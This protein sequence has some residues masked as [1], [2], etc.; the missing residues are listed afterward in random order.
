MFAALLQEKPK[1][2]SFHFGVPAPE[3]VRALRDARVILLASATNP[4]EAQAVADAEIQSDGQK[5]K[6]S[7]RDCSASEIPVRNAAL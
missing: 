6:S 1:V 7:P 2:V 3:R 4:N 5:A